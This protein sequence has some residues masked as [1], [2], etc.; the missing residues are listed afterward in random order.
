MNQEYT[1]TILGSSSATPTENRHH[2]S[3]ILKF[4][5]HKFMIDCG[6]GTQNRCLEYDINFQRIETIFISH[7]H[8]DHYLGLPGL[9]NT[10]NLYS[11]KKELTV[12]TLP[13]LKEIMDVHL[14]I[15]Q[16]QLKFEL[17]IVEI[18]FEHRCIFESEYVKV[19]SFPLDHR[20]PCLG[21]YF[22]EKPGL[23]KL[24]IEACE[25]YKVTQDWYQRLKE[26][27][28]F[29]SPDGEIVSN[30]LFTFEPTEPHRY[31]HV[32]DTRAGVSIPAEIHGAD[33]MYHEAT[34]LHNLKDRATETYHSTA[35]QAGESALQAD[36][37]KL[38][39]GHFSSR[40][41]DLKAH[42]EEAQSVF[43]PTILAIEGEIIPLR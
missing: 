28:D 13:G 19:F 39:I 14:K 23:R 9:I 8:G 26:G 11:R 27:E 40:Y 42:L 31:L 12:Y 38:I 30:K 33:L 2:S 29:T 35:L 41:K 17:N 7:L 5:V 24:N 43:K 32:S 36:A 6:E 18:E 15:S 22:I 25:Y 34:F 4:G 1:L 16:V 37:E 10:M 3:F 21:Y 20:I